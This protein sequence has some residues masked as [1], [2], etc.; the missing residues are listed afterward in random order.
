MSRG[1]NATGIASVSYSIDSINGK[2]EKMKCT[3]AQFD[4][5]TKIYL[6]W[7]DKTPHAIMPEDGIEIV[8]D[9]DNKINDYIGVWVGGPIP[10][11]RDH[12]TAMYLG[13][14]KDGY[15]HS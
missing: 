3:Q 15:T 4:A 2:G 1:F 11:S 7:Q 8:P 6:R 13:I 12:G 10:Q 5:L 9:E 14:E